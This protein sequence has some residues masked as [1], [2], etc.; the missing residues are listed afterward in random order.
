MYA[1]Y[2][3]SKSSPVDSISANMAGN[4]GGLNSNAFFHIL[5]DVFL[6]LV[7]ISLLFP[8]DLALRPKRSVPSYQNTVSQALSVQKQCFLSFAG[9]KDTDDTSRS[10]DW[11]LH[12][13]FVR[14]FYYSQ[15]VFPDT[16]LW[17]TRYF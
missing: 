9:Q 17:G 13:N 12:R 16:L 1:A 7:D 2:R 5:T 4:S 11:L 6:T 3:L 15:L 14:L 8:Y 10:S